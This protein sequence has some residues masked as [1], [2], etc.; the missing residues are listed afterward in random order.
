MLFGHRLRPVTSWSS[1][2]SGKLLEKLLERLVV[3]D[4]LLLLK[5]DKLMTNA[6][7]GLMQV[8]M[9][10]G[11]ERFLSAV[12]HVFSIPRTERSRK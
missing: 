8:D 7:F 9:D 6:R 5:S 11:G 12:L 2:L 3:F 4:R 1:H 10:A